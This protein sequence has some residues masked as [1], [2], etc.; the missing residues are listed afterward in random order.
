MDTRFLE[1]LL[2]VAETG[3]IAAAARQ[4]GLTAAG[5]SQRIRVLEA[6]LGVGLLNRSAHAALPTDACLRLL[7]AAR[8]LVNDAHDLSRHIDPTGLSGPFRLGAVSTGLL[9]CAP[10]VNRLFQEEAPEA[11]LTFRP[12]TSAGLYQ[13]LL[14]GALDAIITVAAPFELPKSLQSTIIATQPVLH[15][16]PPPAFAPDTAALPWIVYDR[17]SWGGRKIWEVHGREVNQGRILCEL[18][19]LETIALM[20]SQ[21]MGQAY[22]PAWNRL[23]DQFPDLTLSS[24]AANS[25]RD[26]VFLRPHASGASALA[27]L[28]LK[29]LQ[30]QVA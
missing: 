30:T 7:P 8:K 12:G 4:Q 15:A 13:D 19:A 21:G 9:D 2:V 3:S 5:V 11:E 1:S 10:A 14:D 16:A 22:I 23:A 24:K 27:N 20:V 29:A 25:H 26:M 6:Q 18:D 28:V 17:A